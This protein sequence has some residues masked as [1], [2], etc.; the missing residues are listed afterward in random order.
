MTSRTCAG[1]TPIHGCARSPVDHLRQS[2]EIGV[3]LQL[4]TDMG[5]PGRFEAG[6]AMA[7]MGHAV[8]RRRC[9]A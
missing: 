3:M 8:D 6:T 4:L 2:V 7:W 9:P 1:P 5:R